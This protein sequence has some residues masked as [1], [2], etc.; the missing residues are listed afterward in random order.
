M[1]LACAQAQD[2]DNAG[3]EFWH[4]NHPVASDPRQELVEERL[5]AYDL[6]LDSLSVFEEK[7]NANKVAAAN[8]ASITDDPE[9]VRSHAY[10]L[11]FASEDEMFHST[12][13]DWLIERNLA[14]DLLEVSSFHAPSKF[15]I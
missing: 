13:Y 6:I 8:G 5:K 11:A 1:P 10:E 4:L 12:L 7:S 9:A 3:L 14:D 2:P 15:C